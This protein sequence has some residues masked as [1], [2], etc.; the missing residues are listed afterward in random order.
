MINKKAYHFT[1]G[2]SRECRIYLVL[3][4]NACMHA[5]K[6]NCSCTCHSPTLL[7]SPFLNLEVAESKWLSKAPLFGFANLSGLSNDLCDERE[8]MHILIF[9]IDILQIFRVCTAS[10]VLG[11]MITVIKLGRDSRFSK[12]QVSGAFFTRS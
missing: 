3:E 6:C 9:D 2:F 8:R 11:M 12:K 1:Y 5:S 10:V 4:S 7:S